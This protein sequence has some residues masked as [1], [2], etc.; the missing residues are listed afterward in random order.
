MIAV[1]AQP[2]GG[3]QTLTNFETT[4]AFGLIHRRDFGLP[5]EQRVDPFLGEPTAT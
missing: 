3:D 4:P 5:C 1:L 2:R